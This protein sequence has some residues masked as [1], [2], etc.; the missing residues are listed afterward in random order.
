[1][2]DENKG[3]WQK[4]SLGT[5]IFL[6]FAALVIS[7][8]CISGMAVII[9]RSIPSVKNTVPQEK[10]VSYFADGYFTVIDKWSDSQGTYYLLKANDTGVL[11]F[12]INSGYGKAITVLCNP[13]GS[14]QTYDETKDYKAL[15]EG[16]K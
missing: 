7:V 8:I 11:Y 2:D 10:Q 4:L 5:K 9:R 1:M 3:Y 6:M 13:D 16:W 12:Y 14:N 15:R